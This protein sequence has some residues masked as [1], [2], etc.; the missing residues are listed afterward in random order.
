MT[1]REIALKIFK[2]SSNGSGCGWTGHPSSGFINKC[3]EEWGIGKSA[4]AIFEYLDDDCRWIPADS[5]YKHPE[6]LPPFNPYTDSTRSSGFSKSGVFANAQSVAD[7]ERYPWPDV[8][9]LDFTDVYNEIERYPDKMVFTGMWSHFFHLV[10]DFFGMEK[11]FMNMYDCPEL[12][13]AVTEHVVSFYEEANDKFFRSLNGRADVMFFGNDFGSQLD[14]LISVKA[15]RRFILPYFKRLI[16]VGKKHNMF[17]MLHSCGSIY[18]IIPDLID[19]GVDAIHPI[20]AAAANMN[21]DSLKQFKNDVAFI[22]GI[23]AQTFF[24]NSTPEQIHDEVRRV[25]DILGP[26]IIISPSHEEILPNVPPANVKAM[27]CEA[28]KIN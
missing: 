12:V 6:G 11:Y 3:A 4:E 25:R 14:L 26:N 13:E 22:G 21:A 1:S 19:A 7:I 28:K 5:G 24:V 10:A 27:M 16:N 18:K 8:K 15:F 20:Q 23:D 2:R 17:I 9:Y